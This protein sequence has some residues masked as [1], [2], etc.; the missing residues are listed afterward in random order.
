MDVN[1]QAIYGSKAW[2]VL[3][4]GNLDKDGNLRKLPGGGLGR[5]H[6]DFKFDKEDFRF[7]VGKDNSLYAVCMVKPEKGEQ[8]LV[9]S[10]AKGNGLSP[11][12]ISEVK[13]LGYDGKLKWKHGKEGLEITFPEMPEASSA[14][15][16][17]KIN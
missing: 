16:T 4:E 3:G 7:T 15:V 1:G 8:L 5:H 2:E 17:F 12:K 9:K 14:A 10:L 11:E 13:L 6:A